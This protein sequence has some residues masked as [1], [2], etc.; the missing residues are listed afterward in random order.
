MPEEELNLLQFASCLMAKP[1]TRST[2]IV[3]SDYP[4]AAGYRRFTNDGPNYFRSEA[5]TVYL[6]CLAY[7][8][9]ERSIL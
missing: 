7:G 5:A 9:E 6:S 3:W 1:S 2:K 4:D 8:A